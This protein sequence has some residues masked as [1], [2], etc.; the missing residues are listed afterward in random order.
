MHFASAAARGARLP[1]GKG[2]SFRQAF[3]VAFFLLFL[4]LFLP[5]N[6]H[7][8]APSIH[9]TDLD[10]FKVGYQLGT[11]ADTLLAHE[12]FSVK[13]YLECPAD[14]ECVGGDFELEFSADVEVDATPNHQL[15]ASSWLGAVGDMSSSYE[16][17]PENLLATWTAART[18]TFSRSGSGMVLTVDFVVGAEDL[19]AQDAVVSLDG[20][21]IIVDNLDLKRP[22]DISTPTSMAVYPNPFQNW[23]AIGG[24]TGTEWQMEWRNAQ[25]RLLESRTAMS[26]ARM[27]VSGFD[28]GIYLLGVHRPG[29]SNRWIRVVKN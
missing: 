19:P 8:Q 20:G 18:D 4:V 29:E 14:L 6:Q 22:H 23:I 2:L 26:G 7:A 1:K 9:W 3:P 12:R 5:Q 24:P 21:I 25:G 11:N 15:P 16:P 10:S 17:G 13:L 27:D 28:P